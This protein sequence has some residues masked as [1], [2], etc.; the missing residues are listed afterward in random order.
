MVLIPPLI[1][2]HIPSEISPIEQH[3]ACRHTSWENLPNLKTVSTSVCVCV[4]LPL[5]AHMWGKNVCVC[6]GLWLRLC[7]GEGAWHLTPLQVHAVSHKCQMVTW[8]KSDKGD[9][10][11]W[12]KFLSAP[13]SSLTY[14]QPLPR[15]RSLLKWVVV[16]VC[17]VVET[18]H[19]Q[20][21]KCHAED[22]AYLWQ[23]Y[24]FQVFYKSVS[25]LSSLS[26]S[27]SFSVQ[28]KK[29]TSMCWARV[30]VPQPGFS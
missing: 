18:L 17:E 25:L 3:L 12:D 21:S 15:A 9:E 8:S 24:C 29:N 26:L 4:C 27:R 2:Y 11:G 1:S 13:S 19:L 6:I 23:C 7:R 5:Q 20:W 14:F 30:A 22:G 10:R 16:C 28:L